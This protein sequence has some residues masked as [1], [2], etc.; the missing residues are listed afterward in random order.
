MFD[1]II[2]IPKS[3]NGNILVIE[4]NSVG[5]K[6]LVSD[7]A[8]EKLFKPDSSVKVYT[9]MAVKEDD[10]S[11]YGFYDTSERD[12]FVYLISV[13][14]V[15][16]KMAL[17]ILSS[18]GLEQLAVAIANGNSQSLSKIK[19]IG[20][21]TANRIILE[22]KE[23][24]AAIADN[25]DNTMTDIIPED[26]NAVFALISLGF[27]KQEAVNAVK[28]AGIGKSTEEIIRIALKGN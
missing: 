5:F 28:N 23:K 10:I 27:S 14:G 1:Y 20:N 19:G 7:N 16:A 25:G 18:I 8:K 3:V 24:M 21:K 6:L 26:E 4:T 11:L 9:Y 12:M 17:A 22:L 2:G 13:S 15:G